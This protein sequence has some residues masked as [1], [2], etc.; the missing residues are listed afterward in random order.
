LGIATVDLG[1]VGRRFPAIAALPTLPQV[2]DHIAFGA[3]LGF[4]LARSR[5]PGVAAPLASAP[6]ATP[7]AR[8]ERA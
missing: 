2:A 6:S 1:L 7:A 5:P 4:A 3:V 8:N